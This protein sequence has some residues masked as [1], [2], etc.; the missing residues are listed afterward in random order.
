MLRVISILATLGSVA[1]VFAAGA[2]AAPKPFPEVIQLPQGFQPEGIEVGKGTTF[3]VGSVA[4]GAVYRGNLRTGTGAILVR[5][6]SGKA[7]TGIELDSRN[8][9]WVAG[10]ATGKAHVYDA[11]TGAPIRT[12]TFASAD[13]FINDVVVTPTAAYFTDSRKAVLY[14]VPIGAGGALGAVQM[15]PVGG[16][17][18]LA[19]GFNLNGID[20]TPNGK[21][22]VAVQS[23]TGKLFRI[24]PATGVARV[25]SLGAESVP[26]G[27][28]IL[29]TGKTLYVVQ[30]QL[31]RVAVIALAPNLASGRVVTRLSDP[32]FAVP[33]TIDDHGRRLYAVNARFGISNPGAA[34]FQ[35][36]Q[37]SKPKGR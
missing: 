35:V 20:S 14:K 15:L 17:F 24:D 1:V 9:L 32:D 6:E 19:S 30:N 16:D 8:R 25:I 10:A 21:T 5:G 34:E 7:A 23:N 18:V 36:V 13:T 33:T 3:Y 28:G 4:N 12:F 31:N 22:L 26:N 29:L 2:T 37:L 27:D 11:R